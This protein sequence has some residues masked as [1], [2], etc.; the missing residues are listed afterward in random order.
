LSAARTTLEGNRFRHGELTDSPYLQRVF[1]RFE[2]M[3]MQQFDALAMQIYG[4]ML[5]TSNL[6]AS[7]EVEDEA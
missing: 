4:P 3:D 6:S 7:A 1:S 5:N 2:D